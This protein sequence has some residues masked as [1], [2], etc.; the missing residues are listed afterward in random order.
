MGSVGV[1]RWP[2]AGDWATTVFAGVTGAMG[3]TG[4]GMRMGPEPI[5]VIGPGEGMLGMAPGWRMGVVCV[6]TLAMWRP[7]EATR[8]EAAERERPIRLGIT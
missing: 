8:A 4:A 7:I 2:A 5:G 1:T 3:A 6:S